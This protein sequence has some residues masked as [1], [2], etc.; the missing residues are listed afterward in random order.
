[1]NEERPVYTVSE[2]TR[3]IK[4]ILEKAFPQV[5]VEGEVSNLRIPSSG[6][7]Y[8]TLKDEGAELHTVM[9]RGLNQYLKF[10]M[11]DG[12]KIVASGTISVY[13]RR[14]EYQLVV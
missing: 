6:H 13:Q 12:L 3:S 9:F 2:L 4:S 11:E 10:K 1:M 8:F 7:M 14:G 5:W